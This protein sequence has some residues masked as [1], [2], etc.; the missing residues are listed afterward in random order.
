MAGHGVNDDRGNYYFLTHEAELDRLRRTAV[1]WREFEDLISG[2]NSKVLF[3][4]DTCHSGNIYTA[5]RGVASSILDAIQSLKDA[6]AGTVIFS[7]TTG[8][9]F[10]YEDEKL[11]HGAF[12]QAVIEG[13]DRLRADFDSDGQITIKELD[14]YI[15]RRVKKLSHKRQKP[16]T[17]IPAAVPDFPIYVK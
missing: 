4:V 13:L 2:L 1:K 9:G 11:G 15:T 17:I 14:L 5:R 10:S 12:T 7:A 8:R 16:T 6:G 3:F